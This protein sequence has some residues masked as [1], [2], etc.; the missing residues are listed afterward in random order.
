MITQENRMAQLEK[1]AP[2]H[3]R[4]FVEWNWVRSKMP[5]RHYHC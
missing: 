4:Q 1:L 3:E 5:R 2:T